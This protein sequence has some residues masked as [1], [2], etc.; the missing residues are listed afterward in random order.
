MATSGDLA[1]AL[2]ELLKEP[3]STVDLYGRHLRAAGLLNVKGQGRGAAEMTARDAAAWL[4]ALAID[5][6]RGG[7]FAREVK[8]VLDLPMHEYL[9]SPKEYADGLAHRAAKTAGHG[10]ALLI[11]D[12][13]VPRIRDRLERGDD[14]VTAN[15]DADGVFVSLSISERAPG[16]V[17]Q[18]VDTLYQRG[19]RKRRDVERLTVIH[20]RVLL[21]IAKLLA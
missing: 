11:G 7:D 19:E 8:R 14:L 10:L 17:A 15:F 4:T 9:L 5:H 21:E 1:K 16:E 18:F 3:F 13:L 12:T 2:S 20:G 6:E